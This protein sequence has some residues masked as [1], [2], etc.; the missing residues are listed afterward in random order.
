MANLFTDDIAL[1]RI[2]YTPNDYTAL[3]SDINSVDPA[4]YALTCFGIQY[5]MKIIELQSD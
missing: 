2:I 3:Q 5:H 1:Y 4:M